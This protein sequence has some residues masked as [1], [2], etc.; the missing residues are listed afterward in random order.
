MK[1]KLLELENFAAIW[2]GLRR[3][4]LRLD[5]SSFSNIIT[6]IVG[7]M[8]SGKTTI[9]SQLHPW[10]NIGTLDER[11]S[12]QL[13]RSELDGTKHIIFVDNGDE[14]EITHKYTWSKD[15]HA[16][17]SF[18]KF[19]GEE[20]NSN[21]NQSSFKE[22]V[23]KFMGVDQSYLRIT[24]IG[25]N[26]SNLIDMPWNQR[27][28]YVASMI[29]SVD[30][31]T[32]IL[33]GI[34][35]KMKTCD[36]ELTT[37]TKQMMNITDKDIEDKINYQTKLLSDI[38]SEERQI[39]NLN[40]SLCSIQAENDITLKKFSVDTIDNLYIL[41]DQKITQSSKLSDLLK[42]IK[43][44]IRKCDSGLDI[45][46]IMKAI[47][48][49]NSDIDTN[50]RLRMALENQIAEQKAQ[51]DVLRTKK[52]N[53]VSDSY[54]NSLSMSYQEILKT[55]EEYNADLKD[56]TYDMTSTEIISL[57][58]DIQ[59]LD[60]LLFDVFSCSQDVVRDIVNSRVNA[61]ANAKTMSEKLQRK[62]L[63]LKKSLS[64][65]Q[66]VGSY[67]VSDQLPNVIEDRCKECP[68][69]KTHPNTLKKTDPSKLENKVQKILAEIDEVKIRIDKYEE[70]PLVSTKI[71]KVTDIF[72]K[73]KGQ[74]KRLNALIHGDM[75]F[76][77]SSGR[78]RIWYNYDEIINQLEKAT[79]YEKR[80][81]ISTKRIEIEN[82]LTKYKN[83][84][85]ASIDEEIHNAELLIADTLAAI[86]E[87]DDD[88]DKSNEDV[89]HYNELTEAY[90]NLDD[91][92]KQEMK[93]S[94]EK[95][96]IDKLIAEIN[97]SIQLIEDNK[98][99][100]NSVNSSY[101]NMLAK[102]NNDKTVSERLHTEITTLQAGRKQISVLQ[103]QKYIYELIRD[104]SSPQ[105]GIPLLYVQLFLNDCITTTN[106]LISM[107][108]DDAIEI[109]DLDLSK[110]DF[111]IPYKKNGEIMEDVKSASQGERAV[112]SLALSF[113]FMNKCITMKKSSDATYNILLLDEIDAPFYKDAREKC[114]GILSQQIKINNIEQVFFITHNNCYEG[115]PI[116][117]IATTD[118]G[119]GKK[120]IPS[121][122]LY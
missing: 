51:L 107:V 101:Q 25:P 49:A 15:H 54:I 43:E 110:P 62:I 117:M 75:K 103:E 105:S 118:T 73:I 70:Y 122:N 45:R 68:Y 83:L 116:N 5:F 86:K 38:E 3:K 111:K 58:S 108:L 88:I 98:N 60:Q 92:K 121:I 16:V 41:R 109:L 14:F 63:G 67:D 71:N 91:L 23:T 104:A 93:L 8:G 42:D 89:R 79:K 20:L 56:F 34:R 27:K 9:L 24:R 7:D 35:Q 65:I 66:F 57:I 1:I 99:E 78:N 115:Y 87:I 50:K 85:I 77:L 18:F 76:I 11:N 46:E 2:V 4:R 113:A 6:V 44:K 28:S 61:V 120:D 37:L 17:K 106:Q 74:V 12:D 97:N 69:Y 33:A 82:E 55:L 94:D 36:A 53:T 30:I 22:L 96:D 47:G 13:I 102:Y 26:V 114:L 81:V 95:T 64:N 90:N 80:S 29:Q 31:Y 59:L 72:E 40:K 19:N 100:Y 48:K 119:E 112:I 21:G 10:A 52:Q 32:E 84:D 39:I